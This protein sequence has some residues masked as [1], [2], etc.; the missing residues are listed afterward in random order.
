MNIW[1]L[2][3]GELKSYWM[4]TGRTQLLNADYEFARSRDAR[5]TTMEPIYPLFLIFLES[6]F[7][8]PI[9]H[10]K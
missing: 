7:K 4:K 10:R 9:P 3:L 2:K 1:P 5:V 8:G 6:I